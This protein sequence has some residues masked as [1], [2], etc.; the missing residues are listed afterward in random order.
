MPDL[1]TLVPIGEARN[2][3]PPAWRPSISSIRHWVRE[4][5]LPSVRIAGRLF[6]GPEHVQ[7]FIR[8]STEGRSCT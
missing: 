3:F 1:A 8:E 4:E 6:I 2:L 7:Q 5:R